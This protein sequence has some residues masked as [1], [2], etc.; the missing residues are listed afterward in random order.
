MLSIFIG[1]AREEICYEGNCGI[2]QTKLIERVSERAGTPVSPELATRMHSVLK[3]TEGILFSSGS[4]SADKPTRLLILDLQR[5]YSLQIA[6]TS[7]K[8]LELVIYQRFE[9]LWGFQACSA[10]NIDPR[11]LHSIALP[12]ENLGIIHKFTTLV[13][14]SVQATHGTRVVSSQL[15]FFRRMLILD[16]LRPD[17][18]SIVRKEL[19]MQDPDEE[20]LIGF[21]TQN[22]VTSPVILESTARDFFSRNIAVDHGSPVSKRL[23]FRRTLNSLAFQGRIVFARVL[24]AS[25]GIYE[26]ALSVPSKLLE[27]P[28]SV[29]ISADAA[30]DDELSDTDE[31]PNEM[32]FNPTDE[33]YARRLPVFESLYTLLEVSGTAGL[34]MNN[35]KDA[36]KIGRKQ[37]EKLLES[38]LKN[39]PV[40]KLP[41]SG[42]THILVTSR[43][44]AIVAPVTHASGT[45]SFNR[46]LALLFGLFL[47]KDYASAA[48]IQREISSIEISTSHATTGSSIDRRT[49]ARLIDATDGVLKLANKA[50]F[51]DAIQAFHVI[52]KPSR[53][54]AKDACLAVEKPVIL[55]KP[56]L[57]EEED[58]SPSHV[59]VAV[60]LSSVTVEDL[61]PLSVAPSDERKLISAHYGFV[62]ACMVR[63]RMLHD[64]L[65]ALARE[66]G[67]SEQGRVFQ[68]A[69][70]V[71]C[72]PVTLYLHLI[73]C[74]R[75][76]KYIDEYLTSLAAPVSLRI[77]DLPRDV[78]V[79]LATSATGN[80]SV[81]YIMRRSLSPLVKL[82]LISIKSD[83]GN[84]YLVNRRV[85]LYSFSDDSSRADYDFAHADETFWEDLQLQASL[86]SDV[87]S[88]SAS[89]RL[90]PNEVFVSSN[91]STQV[92]ISNSQRK[93]LDE[94]CSS[95][96]NVKA[97][98]PGN[99]LVVDASNSKLKQTCATWGIDAHTA[100]KYLKQRCRITGHQADV[101]FA[102]LVS[103]RYRCH[104]CGSVAALMRGIVNHYTRAHQCELPIDSSSYTLPEHQES[105]KRNSGVNE[106]I[107]KRKRVRRAQRIMEAAQRVKTENNLSENSPY[108]LSDVAVYSRYFQVAKRLAGIS[109]LNL[110]GTETVDSL[111][112]RSHSIWDVLAMISGD[113]TT[114][115]SRRKLLQAFEAEQMISG[116][117]RQSL[118]GSPAVLQEV[119]ELYALR[120]LSLHV[121][122]DPLLNTICRMIL[123]SKNDNEEAANKFL[124]EKGFTERDK[125]FVFES[126][127]ALGWVSVLKKN[128]FAIS[129]NL[130]VAVFGRQAELSNWFSLG[131]SRLDP[132]LDAGTLSVEP[133]DEFLAYNVIERNLQQGLQLNVNWSGLAD[134]LQDVDPDDCGGD[135]AI[136]GI[137]MHLRNT[138]NI[139]GSL[140][141]LSWQTD[142]SN[143]EVDSYS[144]VAQELATAAAKSRN[145]WKISRAS[146]DLDNDYT[147]EFVDWNHIDLGIPVENP[148]DTLVRSHGYGYLADNLD[149]LYFALSE[150]H[151]TV[152]AA[153][154]RGIS[155]VDIS[156]IPAKL[157]ESLHTIEIYE[158]LRLSV[159]VHDVAGWKLVAATDC[160]QHVAHRDTFNSQLRWKNAP[161]IVQVSSVFQAQYAPESLA[162][163][164]RELRRNVARY[165]SKSQSA[166]LEDHI[167]PLASWVDISGMIDT[168]WLS[169]V[170]SSSASYILM[171]PGMTDAQISE[172]FVV[173]PICE[174]QTLIDIL[175]ASGIC[176]RVGAGVSLTPCVSG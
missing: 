145:V 173:I 54:S 142:G 19:N 39:Y 77:R 21:V 122:V 91:W 27:L 159:R 104:I 171:K 126:W 102:T 68:V 96:V 92:I 163:G 5:H 29:A 172:L 166:Y 70:F 76:N 13:P 34:T 45:A 9:G 176:K 132:L 162:D 134:D 141:F 99:R 110:V 20:K 67:F 115:E 130:R 43:N 88:L 50:D 127:H 137:G 97:G 89:S 7:F 131:K 6:D 4:Y 149:T 143:L 61:K 35:V 153:G 55:P 36:V 152:K 103:A 40:K 174:I 107:G 75:Y 85:T 133:S 108:Q 28:D 106:S 51:V 72:M 15:L 140:P 79:H 65:V 95:L 73:G 135:D 160:S 16:K 114:D 14:K 168:Q 94:L 175:E 32:T 3:K 147:G 66:H 78:R 49:L 81:E 57:K 69:D 86:C 112:S 111:P 121:A 17:V 170:L 113:R 38:L 165:L 26:S 90:I 56:R 109:D 161:S 22:L 118:I 71:D 12:L 47:S 169:D 117:S 31:E 62:T 154:S 150:I 64:Y 93:A 80:G 8:L 60:T 155:L 44:A 59:G 158:L 37:V 30:R 84:A 1:L 25:R 123:F 151:A 63:A 41:Q 52:Y 10:L 98:S 164:T 119:V 116:V 87:A 167:I 18:A 53:I 82:Q 129:R 139:C 83:S 2:S 58:L 48:D 42:R 148:L 138:R 101:M 136:N 46:R 74:S 157:D 100:L 11:Q 156:S 146:H 124:S 24:N 125:L 144:E 23:L 105:Q 33:M 128:K 120:P